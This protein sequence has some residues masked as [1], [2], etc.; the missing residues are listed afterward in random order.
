MHNGMEELIRRENMLPRG[1]RVLC[2]VSGGGDSVCFFINRTGKTAEQTMK[3]DVQ[4]K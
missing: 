1:C 3:M 2:A 4:Q